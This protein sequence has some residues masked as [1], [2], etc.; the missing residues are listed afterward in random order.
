MVVN[1][2][3]KAIMS[4][5]KIYFILGLAMLLTVLWDYTKLPATAKRLTKQADENVTGFSAI[6]LD[7]RNLAVMSLFA[8]FLWPVVVF[9][10][11]AT[12]KEK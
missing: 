8:F 11:V 1:Q 5:V 4:F 9:W 2:P 10:E 3:T 7:I 6:V 12:S